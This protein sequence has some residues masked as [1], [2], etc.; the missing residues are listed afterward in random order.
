MKY[1]ALVTLSALCVVFVFSCSSD[2][3]HGSAG[4][5][6]IFMQQDGQELGLMGDGITDSTI[7]G[8]NLEINKSS[9]SSSVVAIQGHTGPLSLFDVEKNKVVYDLPNTTEGLSTSKYRWVLWN[10]DRNKLVAIGVDFGQDPMDPTQ[11]RTVVEFLDPSNGK[12]LKSVKLKTDAAIRN[13]H[14]TLSHDEKTLYFL[15]G[16]A[17]NKCEL[18]DEAQPTGVNYVGYLGQ[19]MTIHMSPDGSKL[20]ACNTE[21]DVSVINLSDGSVNTVSSNKFSG[22]RCKWIDPKTILTVYENTCYKYDVQTNSVQ[23]YDCCN[24]FYLMAVSPDGSRVICGNTLRELESGKSIELD[25][26]HECV[27]AWNPL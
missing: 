4:T 26:H 10:L 12:V 18:I 3:K 23:K 16:Y 19:L 17:I 1:H 5:Q 9:T 6:D 25:F 15:N 13:T 22:R 20:V 21:G 2:E 24:S 8:E 14:F 11:T 7:E 27:V